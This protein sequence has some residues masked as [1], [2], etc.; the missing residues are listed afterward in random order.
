MSSEASPAKD[1]A[2]QRETSTAV[3][4]TASKLR[5]G[6]LNSPMQSAGSSNHKSRLHR[7]LCKWSDRNHPIQQECIHKT[8]HCSMSPLHRSCTQP[9][10]CNLHKMSI[11]KI[12]RSPLPPFADFVDGVHSIPSR[13]C[14]LFDAKA[15]PF[16]SG[17]VSSSYQRDVCPD[18]PR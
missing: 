7:Y 18:N 1:V 6:A 11:H 3:S 17:P 16:K 9:R 15:V 5:E 14:L 4:T 13:F 12:H 8:K 2:D 10:P